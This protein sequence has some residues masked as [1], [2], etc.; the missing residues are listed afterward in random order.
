ML[1][2]LAGS[3]INPGGSRGTQSAPAQAQASVPNDAP[4]KP[5]KSYSSKKKQKQ[6]EGPYQI[7]CQ[8]TE[9]DGSTATADL[10]GTVTLKDAA[11]GRAILSATVRA[12]G[13]RPTS[14]S[15]AALYPDYSSLDVVIAFVPDPYETR[16][17][18]QFDQTI[19]ALTW[20]VQDGGLNF[21]DS[22]LPWKVR[23]DEFAT[24]SDRKAYEEQQERLRQEPGVLDNE[25]AVSDHIRARSF[26]P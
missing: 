19:E 8:P 23:D 1:A 6:E 7:L 5:A 4:A 9:S 2:G 12:Q 25:R 20:A 17:R 22:W 13:D 14:E 11:S 10:Q 21:R 18:L 24:Y 26:G 16:L 3:F 15:C